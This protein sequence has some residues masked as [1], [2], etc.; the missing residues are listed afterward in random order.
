M[1]AI[2]KNINLKGFNTFGV[3]AVA[4]YFCRLRQPDELFDLFEF[5]EIRAIVG[6]PGN[7]LVLGQGSNILFTGDY[8]GLVIK[9]EIRGLRVV[10][11]NE[12][13]ILVEAGAGELWNDLVG[14][15]VGRGWSGMEN[16]GGIPGT[17][18]AA[19]VQNI[20]A[21]GV[22][23]SSLIERVTAWHI[24]SKKWLT[25]SNADC[26]FGYRESVFKNELRNKAIIVSVVFRLTKGTRA[27]ALSYA[28]LTEELV[29]RNILNPDIS[30]V[31]EVVQE[32]RRTRLPDQTV[33]GNAGSFFK[34]PVIDAGHKLRLEQQYPDLKSNR[35][36]SGFKIP[37]GWLIEKAGWKGHRR[38]DAGC[39]KRQALILVNYGKATGKDILELS[40][41]IQ[42]SV[43]KKF[44]IP[45]ERE[46]N[47]IP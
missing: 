13:S 33:M 35:H 14:Q 32:V 19:P 29:R 18:G 44:G 3:S 4:A 30:D 25:L 38:G 41:R 17:V 47:L 37:A 45:L 43:L 34:N 9:N 11:E 23:V 26:Q 1:I 7:F 10:E 28:A 40:E 36:G 24:D 22:E 5:E 20:G 31:F 8:S 46:V 16:L 6:N 27:L 2:E 21:Y 12:R 39:Y 42:A 15:A